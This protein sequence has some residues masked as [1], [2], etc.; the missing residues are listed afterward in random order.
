MNRSKFLV[1]IILAI[2]VSGCSI[3]PKFY[4]NDVYKN[5][6]KEQRDK[7]I[8]EC[9]ELADQQEVSGGQIALGVVSSTAALATALKGGSFASVYA[10]EDLGSDDSDQK[11]IEICLKKKGYEVTGWE[12]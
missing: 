3:Q 10:W 2:V 11:F 12:I 6:S 8:A 9:K 1:F 5:T 4:P 7:D